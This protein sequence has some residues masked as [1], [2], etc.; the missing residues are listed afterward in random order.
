MTRVKKTTLRWDKQEVLC[1]QKQS[2]V[3]RQTVTDSTLAL[4]TEEKEEC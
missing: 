3:L 1:W 4:S 2:N